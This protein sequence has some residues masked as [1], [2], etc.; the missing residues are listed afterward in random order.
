MRLWKPPLFRCERTSLSAFPRYNPA[1][2]FLRFLMLLA[3][4]VWVGGL[5]FFAFVMAPAVFIV[6]PTR[7]LAGSVVART[8]PQL[9]WM[10][11]VAGV[12]FLLASAFY[13]RITT[14]SPRGFSLAHIFVLLM[15]ALTAI[16]QFGIVPRMVVLRTAMVQI[17]S[18]PLN[19]PLR[20]QFDALHICS[21]RLEG[22][23]LLLGLMVIY[24]TA[25]PGKWGRPS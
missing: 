16:S 19:N 3:L 12:V 5:V 25:R 23:V 18:F 6:V 11:M 7:Q 1:M 8:L 24:L 4:V 13:N 17:D 22:A 2:S 21:T 10:G 14:G 20:M 9:H 15:L